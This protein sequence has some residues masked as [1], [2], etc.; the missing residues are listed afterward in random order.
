MI[1]ALLLLFLIG[2]TVC[3]T[4]V[5][6]YADEDN[7]FTENEAIKEKV[8]EYKNKD[9][10]IDP[11]SALIIWVLFATAFLRI[12][13][14][15]DSILRSMG[16][17]TPVGNGKGS[18]VNTA[19][20]VIRTVE[21]ASK[22]YRNN[23]KTLAGIGGSMKGNKEMEGARPNLN[24]GFQ[25]EKSSSD[26]T[27]E[28][29]GNLF[30]SNENSS[31]ITGKAAQ[32]FMAGMFGEN[33]SN[34]IV[35]DPGKIDELKAQHGMEGKDSGI[36]IDMGKDKNGKQ[37]YA[38]IS[39]LSWGNGITG[40]FD[41]K[42]FQILNDAQFSE[43]SSEEQKEYGRFAMADGSDAYMKWETGTMQEDAA[44]PAGQNT[45]YE[46]AGSFY[47][48]MEE[49]DM[50]AEMP[51]FHS[52]QAASFNKGEQPSFQADMV[53]SEAEGRNETT[54][55]ES[56]S[57]FQIENP[58]FV[59]E[60]FG[61]DSLGEQEIQREAAAVP[62]EISQ[63]VVSEQDNRYYEAMEN[64]IQ[65]SSEE[66]Y[67]NPEKGH[68]PMTGGIENDQFYTSIE[69]GISDSSFQQKEDSKNTS[70]SSNQEEESKLDL[71]FKPEAESAGFTQNFVNKEE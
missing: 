60:S 42:P 68:K 61:Y 7:G 14:Q 19:M 6:V 56:I 65:T 21:S 28:F 29:A 55:Y 64:D 63:P 57:S 33:F 45:D 40:E 41:G 37:E 32:D 34:R 36:W 23:T 13:Q 39:N 51:A 62:N 25:N 59:E 5:T 66:A 18:V 47:P 50:Q 11:I 10:E 43:L 69:T 54:P 71:G 70:F 17:G 38:N 30:R 35:T 67:Y 4:T 58:E 44:M 1:C 20:Q 52:E 27:K 46:N 9:F 31:P 8:E 16:I 49:T 26:I 53:S 48:N 12:A 24:A 15:M 2:S 22:M 3:M